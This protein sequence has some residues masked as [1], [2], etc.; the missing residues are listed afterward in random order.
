MIDRSDA[1]AGFSARTE[2]EP[3]GKTGTKSARLRQARGN[4]QAAKEGWLKLCASYPNFSGADLA[5][6][7]AIATYVN[8]K[9]LDAW[10]SIQ[11]LADDVNRDPS[12]VWKSLQRL[13]SYRL[14]DVVHGRGRKKSN[15][16]R[17]RLG[18]EIDPATL[19]RKTSPRGAALRTRK[20]KSAGSQSKGCELA[21]RTYEEP[22]TKCREG[23]PSESHPDDQLIG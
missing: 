11:R 6:V 1:S 13:E 18:T 9:T 21:G 19:S 8:S 4:F 17:L 3:Y 2:A 14:L 12:T 15:R 10:P 23:L 5:V 20:Q 16:Y 7:I 22:F